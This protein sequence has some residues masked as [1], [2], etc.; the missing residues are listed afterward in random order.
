M[1]QKFSKRDQN[2]IIHILLT[3]YVLLNIYVVGQGD[4]H[5]DK[6]GQKSPTPLP[7][8]LVK[9]VDT[10]PLFGHQGSPADTSQYQ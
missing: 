9:K 2:T 6:V 4:Q 3:N 7:L 5:N 8:H 10:P 1:T